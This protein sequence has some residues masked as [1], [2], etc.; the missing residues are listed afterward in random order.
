M[1]LRRTAAVVLAAA[2]ALTA[3]SGCSDDDPAAKEREQEHPDAPQARK[4]LL[5]DDDLP[6]GWTGVEH[7]NDP[8]HD[9]PGD[10]L[11][12]CMGR[13]EPRK[14]RTT[15]QHAKDY[16]SGGGLGRGVTVAT[17]GNYLVDASEVQA[18]YDAAADET[19]FLPCFEDVAKTQVKEMLPPG[20]DIISLEI[21]KLDPPTSKVRSLLY[22][23][24]VMLD[25]PGEPLPMYIDEALLYE[26]RAET[27]MSFTGASDP[28]DA[29]LQRT[30]IDTAAERL[31]STAGAE[32]TTTTTGTV[33]T[34]TTTTAMGGG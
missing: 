6:D 17:S 27:T 30:L 13:P 32:T 12:R 25:A 33:D 22:R 28:F 15:H 11:F 20:V 14:I 21:E 5:V 2:L 26:G 10:R 3:A 18:D 4:L 29:E 16:S 1:T 31:A 24:T 19:T 8:D 9:K 23:V 34:S 7:P